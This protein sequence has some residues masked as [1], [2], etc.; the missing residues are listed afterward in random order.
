MDPKPRLPIASG[1]MTAAEPLR[2][3]KPNAGVQWHA[4]RTVKAGERMRLMGLFPPENSP[5]S[6]SRSV[7]VSIR[8]S[9]HVSIT[10]ALTWASA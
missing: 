8:V 1:A 10:S 4:G 7:R 6:P 2:E 5:L 9:T 3:W